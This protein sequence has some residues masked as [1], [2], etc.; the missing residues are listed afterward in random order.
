MTS[1]EVLTLA[2]R[3]AWRY[4]KSS[5]PHH[6]DIYTF[7]R[8]TLLEFARKL[9]M[10]ERESCAKVC[11]AEAVKMEEGARR[12]IESGEHDEVSAIRS[13]AWKLSVAAATIRAR[14]NI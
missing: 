14:S 1:D 5:D 4:K 3:E 6:S 2:H 7:N 13:T 10:T 11:D 8:S 12:A 9:A